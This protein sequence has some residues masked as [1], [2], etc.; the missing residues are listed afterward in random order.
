MNPMKT[1]LPSLSSTT[2]YWQDPPDAKYADFRSSK[3]LPKDADI[4][5]IGAGITGAAAAY[6]LCS[7][8]PSHQKVVLLE[9]RQTCSGA[10]GRNGNRDRSHPSSKVMTRSLTA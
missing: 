8:G 4:V 6:K 10:T 5:V 1:V 9:A 7:D 3:D 2:S